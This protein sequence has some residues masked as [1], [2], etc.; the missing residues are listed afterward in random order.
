MVLRINRLFAFCVCTAAVC[1]CLAVGIITD[2]ITVTAAADEPQ[3]LPVVMYHKLTTRESR[4]GRYNLTCEQFEQDL[5]FLKE[6]GYQTITVEQLIEFMDGTGEL[7]KNPIMLTF[8]D[9]FES[10]YSYALPLLEKYDFTAVAFIIGSVTDYYSYLDDH[11][12]SYSCMDWETVRELAEGGRIEIQSHSYDLHKMNGG[13]SGAKKK[14]GESESEYREFLTADL[15]TMKNLMD[16]NAGC[17]PT[18]FAYPYG[19]YSPESVPILKSLG[20]RAVFVCEERVNKIDK[21]DPEW[22]FRIGRYNRPAGVS[23]AKFF[24]KMGIE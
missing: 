10:V 5:A 6:K 11:N 4:A 9:G 8:D 16:E 7:P 20:L 18:A 14:R 19:S 3:R 23:T 24:E 2:S 12:L 21:A 13:R 15:T 1:I 17:E 22:L